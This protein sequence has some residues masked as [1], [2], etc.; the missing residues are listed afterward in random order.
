MA[1]CPHCNQDRPIQ[2]QTFEGRCSFCGKRK[3][4]AHQADCRGPVAGALDVCT[5]CNTPVFAKALDQSQYETMLAEEN[6]IV[7]SRCFIVTATM[8]SA[9]HPLV[10]DMREF[11]D[12][13]LSTNRFG[14]SFIN[15]YDIYGPLLADKIA[16]NN[17]WK[18]LCYILVVK[19][20]HIAV[21]LVLIGRKLLAG[22]DG[23][24]QQF[25]RKW[26]KTS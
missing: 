17:H 18:T 13:V 10:N 16:R 9:T 24:W 25:A 14:R 22:H 19:P 4:E 21:S 1:W 3:A 15:Q 11:R 6:K 20:V 8:G 7:R 23:I 2:R 12:E 5:Y 26:A